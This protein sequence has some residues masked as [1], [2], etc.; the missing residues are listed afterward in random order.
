MKVEEN[1]DKKETRREKRLREKEEQRRAALELDDQIT[2]NLNDDGKSSKKKASE[3]YIEENLF[4][5][6]QEQK[7]EKVK[8]VLQL[9]HALTV[10]DEHYEFPPV[11]LLSEG[12][13]NL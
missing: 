9:E 11:Q 6:E 1:E 7:Q 13:K 5:K 8:E 10:E 12:E 3:G 2:I 4:K